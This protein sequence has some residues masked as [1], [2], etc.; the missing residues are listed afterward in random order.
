MMARRHSPEETKVALH[1][2][3]EEMYNRMMKGEAPT[4]TLP[5]RSKYRL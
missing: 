3:V 2:V 5:V 1:G 4:M